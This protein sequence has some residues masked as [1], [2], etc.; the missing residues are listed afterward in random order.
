MKQRLLVSLLLTFCLGCG[1]ELTFPDCEELVMTTADGELDECD[2][3]ACEAAFGDGCTECVVLQSFAQQYVDDD[4][5]RWDVF[6]FCPN[7]S[8]DT[9]LDG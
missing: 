7:W 3:Q 8:M 4:G 2:L 9:G 1:D 5:E 6:D